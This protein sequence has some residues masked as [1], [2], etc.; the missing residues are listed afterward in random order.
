MKTIRIAGS[1][2]EI[3]VGKILCLGQNYA[4]H[5]KEMSSEVP[6]T[7]VIFLKP[8]SALISNGETIVRPS[9]SKELHH[10]VELVVLIGKTGKGIPQSK[11]YEYVAGYAVGL[12]MTLRDVQSEAKKKG[13]PWA[14]AKGFDTSAAVSE[15]VPASTIGNPLVQEIRCTVNGSVR[16]HTSTSEMIFSVDRIISYVSSIFTL[17][18]GDLIFTGTPEG[19]SEVKEGD[20]IE[21]ELVGHT[22]ISHKVKVA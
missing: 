4:A 20:V 22:K 18:T 7:P 12:D 2:N 19:V 15:F 9:I 8:P 6:T 14:V 11:A 17:E 10:E 21:A 3:A 1:K 16:Q 5:A 13:Q